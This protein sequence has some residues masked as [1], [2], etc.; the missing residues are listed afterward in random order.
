MRGSILEEIKL[1]QWW[2]Y[3]EN[4]EGISYVLSIG[5][6]N[7]EALSGCAGSG[8][9]CLHNTFVMECKGSGLGK[10]FSE[11]L[12]MPVGGSRKQNTLLLVTLHSNDVSSRVHKGFSR[13]I[14]PLH[15]FFISLT[16]AHISGYHSLWATGRHMQ[17]IVEVESD[18]WGFFLSSLPEHS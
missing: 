16:K 10:K 15:W 11:C 7:L 14:F 4:T 13:M 2:L 18:T 9:L 3:S 12:E 1:S 17:L 6:V 5:A 8:L